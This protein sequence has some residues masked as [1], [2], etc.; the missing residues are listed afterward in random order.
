MVLETLIL[1]MLEK[2]EKTGYLIVPNPMLLPEYAYNFELGL[3]KYLNKEKNYISIQGFTTLIS[4]IL[5][6]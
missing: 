4:D 1:T 2:S 5:T 3:T 6:K